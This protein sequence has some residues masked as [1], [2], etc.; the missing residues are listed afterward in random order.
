MAQ[1][2]TMEDQLGISLLSVDQLQN[3]ELQMKICQRAQQ[4]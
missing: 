1:P 3:D 2:F 4:I